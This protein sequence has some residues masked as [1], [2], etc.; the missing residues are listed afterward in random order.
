MGTLVGALPPHPCQ[1]DT[2]PLE[3]HFSNNDSTKGRRY[4]SPPFLYADMGAITKV[5]LDFFQKIAGS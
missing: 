4:G 3:S 2:I 1:R 5:L